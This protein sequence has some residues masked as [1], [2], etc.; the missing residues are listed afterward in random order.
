MRAAAILLAL[1][2]LVAAGC[3]GGSATAPAVTAPEPAAPT[4]AATAGEVEAREEVAFPA[5]TGAGVLALAAQRPAGIV[6]YDVAL[7]GSDAEPPAT[8]TVEI[9]SDDLRAR[10]HQS[11]AEGD[12]WVGLDLN[13]RV[14]TYTCTA[15]VG[16]APECVDGDPDGGASRIA[17]AIARLVGNDFV[18][19]SFAPV[20]AKTADVGVGP[21]LQA[22][23][24]AVSCLATSGSRLCVSRSGFI[25]ELTVPGVSVL[26]RSVT[27]E[28]TPA[29]LDPPTAA[30]G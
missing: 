30:P 1:P 8:Y 5:T 10:L 28:V 23:E 15:P 22:G 29:D 19:A 24:I 9:G 17:D 13:G 12:T 20:A 4:A 3:G 7:A 14:V 25:T 18:V 16:Q 27:T 6:A 21:D 2:L 26:A 11:L